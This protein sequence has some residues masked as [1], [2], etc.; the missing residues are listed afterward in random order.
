MPTLKIEGMQCQ[1]CVAT[2]TKTLQAIGG[3]SNVRVDLAN[4][5]A[6]FDGTPDPE[7]VKQAVAAKGFTVV[8][9]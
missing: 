8:D 7:E 2:V 4:K 5:T 3:V 1:H 9:G 6:V